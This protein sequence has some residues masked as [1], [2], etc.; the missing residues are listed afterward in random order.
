MSS[1]LNPVG[2]GACCAPKCSDAPAFRVPGPAGENAFTYTAGS[3]T[4]PAMGLSV[5]VAMLDAL[6]IVPGQTIFI[7]DAGNMTV[8]SVSGN[9]V[10]VS[11]PGYAGEHTGRCAD[12]DRKESKPGWSRR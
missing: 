8:V 4:M 10:T 5:V 2:G 3:F 1:P 12:R 6:W 9:N 11:N 7:Q